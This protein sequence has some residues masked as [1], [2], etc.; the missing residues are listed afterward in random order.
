M[1]HRLVH[2]EILMV[3]SRFLGDIHRL[4]TIILESDKAQAI[5]QKPFPVE[6]PLEQGLQTGPNL[7]IRLL[8]VARLPVQIGAI[9]RAPWQEPIPAGGQRPRSGLHTIG[10]HQQLVVAEEVGNLLLVG[11]EL[12]VGLAQG[13]LF[14]GR[15]F[16]L[17]HRQRESVNEHHDIR[18]AH[19]LARH[20]GELIHRQPVVVFRASRIHQPNLSVT[21]AIFPH[22]RDVH[23]VG[24]HAV[25]G[26]V[27]LD[28]NRSLRAHHFA[29]R[30]VQCLFGQ[31]RVETGKGSPQAPE[32]HHVAIGSLR[33]TLRSGAVIS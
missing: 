1:L 5:V 17:N 22:P 4:A 14:V 16:K 28:E 31:V 13:G 15:V 23:A 24:E 10:N 7:A 18:P 33:F 8:L 11:L 12:I 2:S 29:R 27:V 32:Q 3:G 20:H 6:K 21:L 9:H 30:L 26:T 19:M 25:E